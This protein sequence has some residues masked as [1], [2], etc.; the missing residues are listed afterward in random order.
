MISIKCPVD[1][2]CDDVSLTARARDDEIQCTRTREM[3]T[4][5]IKGRIAFPLARKTITSQ[6][7]ATS[8]IHTYLYGVYVRSL[9]YPETTFLD[10]VLMFL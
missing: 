2:R 9:Y 8:S 4:R 6:L 5:A 1:V 10:A 7:E 3:N